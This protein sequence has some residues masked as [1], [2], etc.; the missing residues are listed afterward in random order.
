MNST[1][2]LGDEP[3]SAPVSFLLA[4]VPR[5]WAAH[6]TYLKKQIKG[7]KNHLA[8]VNWETRVSPGSKYLLSFSSRWIKNFLCNFCASENLQHLEWG[9]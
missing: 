3:A 6:R 5:R 2:M 8:K 1:G 4:A 9:F 7:P